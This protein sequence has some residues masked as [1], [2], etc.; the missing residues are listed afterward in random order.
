MKKVWMIVLVLCLLGTV[1]VP[2]A[3]TESDEE[4]ALKCTVEYM[5]N[6]EEGEPI[7]GGLSINGYDFFNVEFD[8]GDVIEYEVYLEDKIPGLGNLDVQLSKLTHMD[9]DGY[10]THDWRMLRPHGEHMD[11]EI[12]QDEAG[13]DMVQTADLTEV[14]Y[15]TWYKRRVTVP[16][17]L[18]D[19]YKTR[20]WAVKAGAT[21]EMGMELEGETATVYYKNIRVLDKDGNVKQVIL[22]AGSPYVTASFF[23]LNGISMTA[24]AVLDYPGAPERETPAP[25]T[26][27]AEE[28][29]Q[30]VPDGDTQG[31][32]HNTL[33]ICII[34]GT[35]VIAA[36]GIAVIV[37]VKKKKIGKAAEN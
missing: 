8:P 19:G 37:V 6:P 26:E 22:G 29:E 21:V 36:A 25:E 12:I 20:H 35:T 5:W 30:T 2:A 10:E 13:I 1:I 14:A 4:Y 27:P 16:E 3:A 31:N 23:D 7:F 34:L 32:P 9:E 28:P 18:T 15:K 24:E 33:F 11:Q 17:F